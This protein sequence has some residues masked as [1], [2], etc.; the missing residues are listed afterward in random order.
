MINIEN[1]IWKDMFGFEGFYEVSNLG[2]HRSLSRIQSDGKKLI[3][4]VLKT[5]VSKDGY[6][7][8][9]LST[10]NKK[11]TRYLHRLILQSFHG[12][13]KL[14][15]NHK[16]GIKTDNRLENL[17]Y[18]TRSENLKHAYKLGLNFFTDERKDKIRNNFA[19]THVKG[20]KA[21][22]KRK[23]NAKLHN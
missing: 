7:R 14:D 5:R 11:Y 23:Q 20:Y 4:R 1:E 21:S 13:S 12:D 6:I 10:D 16:N 3:G 17:E 15:V 22:L 8:V 19:K 18:V 2:N 9:K